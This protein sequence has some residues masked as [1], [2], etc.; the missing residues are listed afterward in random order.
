VPSGTPSICTSREKAFKKDIITCTPSS[1]HDEYSNEQRSNALN[2]KENGDRV[3]T[4]VVSKRE[5]SESQRHFPRCDIGASCCVETA[6]TRDRETR[7]GYAEHG[8]KAARQRSGEPE[9]EGETRSAEAG[10]T[11]S[12]GVVCVVGSPG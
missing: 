12:C 6:T 2:G 3:G 7:A 11:V 5:S 9:A 4:R 10:A 1:V 8:V